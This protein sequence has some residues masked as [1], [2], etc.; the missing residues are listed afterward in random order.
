MWLIPQPAIAASVA[1]ARSWLIPPSAA[2]PKMTRVEAWPVDPNWAVGSMVRPYDYR[3]AVAR[4]VAEMLAMMRA[5]SKVELSGHRTDETFGWTKEAAKA[6][7]VEELAAVS[8]L[9][10]RLFAEG[11]RA[12]LVV[13]QAMDAGGKDGTIRTVMTGVNPAGV[14]VASF[15]VPSEEEL[16]HD[17]LWRIHQRLPARGTIGVFNRSH[18]EDVLVVRV[19]GLVPKATWQRRYRQIRSFE[20][21]LVAEGTSVVKLFLHVSKDEQRARM[22]DRIDDPDERWK[23]RKGDLDDRARWDDYMAAF[24]DALRKTSTD[25]APWYVVPADRKWARNLAVARI[26]RHHLELLDPQYP[27]PEEDIAGLV[28][29]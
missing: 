27:E 4:N 16:A 15:G 22:Q 26:L 9:Q 1:S 21:M 29:T 19:H 17:Y 10:T 28:V 14:E 8:D 25:D 12:L 20:E 3:H 11:R 5:G 6:A 23:F 18:Y 24:R 2:A 13:L 7:L